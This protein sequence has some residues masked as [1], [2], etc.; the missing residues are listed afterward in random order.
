MAAK[1]ASLEAEAR[2]LRE[3][4]SLEKEETLLKQKQE[5]E[6]QCLKQEKELILKTEHEK[7]IAELH[8]YAANK[9]DSSNVEKIEQTSNFCDMLKACK[10]ERKRINTWVSDTNENRIKATLSKYPISCKTVLSEVNVD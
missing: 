5:I 4:R 8:V 2:K 1:K 10:I 3:K 6:E 9:Q 7:V